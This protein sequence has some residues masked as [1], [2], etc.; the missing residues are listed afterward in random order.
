MLKKSGSN[1]YTANSD[2][3]WGIQQW[4]TLGAAGAGRC[5]QRLSWRANEVFCAGNT[6][7]VSVMDGRWFRVRVRIAV[8]RFRIS[9]ADTLTALRIGYGELCKRYY[10]M[11]CWWVVKKTAMSSTEH[12][13]TACMLN[14]LCE[15]TENDF[16]SSKW[17]VDQNLKCMH[18]C[19]RQFKINENSQGFQ[20]GIC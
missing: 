19:G 9:T 8:R 13:C 3:L 11:V 18:A 5:Q 20:T 12:I 16:G 15:N 2:P 7:V 14:V 10:L 6:I 17:P 1:F 4:G